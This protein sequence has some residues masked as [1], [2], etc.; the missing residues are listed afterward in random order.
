VLKNF[1]QNYNILPRSGVRAENLR[2]GS[3]NMP[4]FVIFWPTLYTKEDQEKIQ[5]V[6]S[7]ITP[8]VKV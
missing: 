1:F 3:Q 6:T 8:R 7:L 5:V 4:N 2:A